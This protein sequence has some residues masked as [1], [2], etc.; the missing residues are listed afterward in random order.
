MGRKEKEERCMGGLTVNDFGNPSSLVLTAFFFST[1]RKAGHKAI[2][3][4]FRLV[5]C[6]YHT[7]TN[8]TVDS[9]RSYALNYLLSSIREPF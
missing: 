7:T 9:F 2:S 4:V 8:W 5:R 6:C 3:S 1:T